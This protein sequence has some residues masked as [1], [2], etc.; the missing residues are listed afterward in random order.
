[1]G[2]SNIAAI[3]ILAGIETIGPA[4][5][6]S[7]CYDARWYLGA[8]KEYIM[9]TTGTLFIAFVDTGH[10]LYVKMNTTGVQLKLASGV[11][12][13]FIVRGWKHISDKNIDQGI[14][15]FYTKNG[16]LYYRSYIQTDDQLFDWQ[17]EQQIN[18]S[19]FISDIQAYRT[20]DFR[21]AICLSYIDNSN[22]LLLTDRVFPG[23]SI[24][25][26]TVNIVSSSDNNIVVHPI[27]S[28]EQDYADS[29]TIVVTTDSSA[30]VY[31]SF[32]NS[33]VSSKNVVGIRF[34]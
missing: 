9:Y 26:E 17:D 19:K 1:V 15:V 6:I 2:K 13:C 23:Q 16:S 3:N 4:K 30:A 33:N 28:V 34:I 14:N 32:D 24:P 29:V 22:Q 31:S 18:V 25:I 8:N 7:I 12:R 20:A 10:N 11:D 27:I 21:L 5:D